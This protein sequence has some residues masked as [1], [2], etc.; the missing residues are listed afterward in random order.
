MR[1]GGNLCTSLQVLAPTVVTAVTPAGAVG[2]AAIAITTAGGTLATP[3]PFTYVQ[4]AISSI[5]PNTGIYAG[6]TEITI[7]GSY[8]NGVVGVTIGG[9]PA[10][11]VVSVSSTTVTAVTPAGSVGAVN[12]VVTGAKG[13]ATLTGGFY[14]HPAGPAW[15]T[16]VEWQPDP[17]VIT[18]FGIR[19]DIIATGLPWRVRDCA[20][21]IEMRLVPPG[22][23]WMGCNSSTSYGCFSDEYPIHL[24]TLTNA[25]YMGKTEVTQAQWQAKMGSNP[26][27]FTG[28]ADSPSR[29]VERVSWNMV[30]DFNAATGL[31]LPTEAEWEYAICKGGVYAFHG[32]PGYPSGTDNDSLLV[33][34]AWYGA[35]SGSQTHAVGGKFAN[36]LGLYDMSGNV[37]EWCQDWYGAYSAANVTNPTGPA[38]GTSRVVR[39]GSWV[40]SPGNCRSSTRA[41]ASPAGSAYFYDGFRVVRNP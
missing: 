13:T 35:N 20:S 39:G 25:F 29:P 5:V 12:V 8:L 33:D 36:P 24:V 9:V 6:G 32:F 18:N 19:S 16:V 4:S 23:I 15:A 31:R 37:Y 38:S 27:F 34:I 21:G 26:S 1:I 11:N 2:Q 7:T 40:G 30:Q 10:A 22:G 14:Y 17:A 41:G 28:Y 3:S